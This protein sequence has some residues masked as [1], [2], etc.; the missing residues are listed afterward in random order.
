VRE[1][2]RFVKP[3]VPRSIRGTATK[4]SLLVPTANYWLLAIEAIGYTPTVPSSS[5]SLLKP[6]E[7]LLQRSLPAAPA[8]EDLLLPRG[9]P[10][11]LTNFDG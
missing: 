11:A 5:A 6:S 1:G 2:L 9:A 3:R 8:C 7:R 10:A 4:P